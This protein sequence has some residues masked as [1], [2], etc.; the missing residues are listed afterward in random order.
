MVQDVL[1]IEPIKT[2]ETTSLNP[3][4]FGICTEQAKRRDAAR[5]E[6]RRKEEVKS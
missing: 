3:P 2:V 1:A 6:T 4:H 5:G